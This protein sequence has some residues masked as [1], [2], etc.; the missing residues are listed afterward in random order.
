MKMVCF[1][2][3][4][5]HVLSLLLQGLKLALRADGWKE[6]ALTRLRS[7]FNCDH[8]HASFSGVPFLKWKLIWCFSGVM[9][10]LMLC[11]L[12]TPLGL[13]DEGRLILTSLLLVAVCP[14]HLFATQQDIWHS[15]LTQH[16]PGFVKRF[17]KKKKKKGR[18]R[19]RFLED[20]QGYT[21]FNINILSLLILTSVLGIAMGY[22]NAHLTCTQDSHPCKDSKNFTIGDKYSRTFLVAH[23]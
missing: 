18:E 7:R 14:V 22:L 6:L 4:H 21:Y 16:I 1:P 3:W 15:L 5:L 12:Q 17:H 9:F 19:E 23:W 11:H 8:G 13:S 10:K 2:F 20:F